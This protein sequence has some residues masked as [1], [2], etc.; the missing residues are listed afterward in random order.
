M[1]KRKKQAPRTARSTSKRSRRAPAE[2]S[3]R[4][5]RPAARATRRQ[6]PTPSAAPPEPAAADVV[7][8]GEPDLTQ[9]VVYIHGIGRHDDRDR[10]KEMWDVALFGRGMGRETIGA[11]WADIRH[12]NASA[13]T[14]STASSKV[15]KAAERDAFE[16]RLLSQLG[17]DDNVAGQAYGTKILPLP[18]FLRTPLTKAF[19]AAFVKDT[20]AY[21]YDDA[22]RRAMRQRLLDVIKPLRKEPFV[23]VAHS[24]GTMIAYDVLHGLEDACRVSRFVTLGSPLGIQEVQDR[25]MHLLNIKTSP[26]LPIPAGV[27]RWDNFAARFDPVAADPVLTD[28]FIGGKGIVRDYRI[29]NPYAWKIRDF[30]PHDSRGYLAD[31]EVRRVVYRAVG[32]DSTTRFVV[33]RDVM[34]A[35]SR[36]P[37]E[38][39]PEAQRLPVLIEVL[40]PQSAAVGETHA[41]MLNREA[42]L[43]KKRAAQADPTIDTLDGRIAVLEGQLTKLVGHGRPPAA[44]KRA[45]EA[46]RIQ[47]LRKYV[48]AHLTP[49]EVEELASRPGDHHVYAIWRNSSKRKLLTRSHGPLAAD[50]ARASY[51]ADG[52]GITWAVLDTGCQRGHP[53]FSSHDTV[54]DVLDCTTADATPQ[55][56][57]PQAADADGHGTHVCGI[58]AGQGRTNEAPPRDVL[59]IAPKARLVVYKVL[60]D[61]GRGE[62]AWII[63]AIDHIF[64]T[65]QSHPGLKIHGVNLSLGG[66]Y[67][68]SIY[69]CGFS[70][71]CKELRDLWRQGVVVCVAAGN[72]GIL[73]VTSGGEQRDLYAPLSIGDPANLDDCIA[74]GSVNADK[75]HLHG[76]S[77][78]SSRGPTADGRVKPD[79]VAPGE[80]ILSCNADFAVT[81][82]RPNGRKRL[83]REDSGTSMA[84]PHVSGLI[85]AF[86]SL[87][88]EFIGRPDEVKRIVLENC[89]DL[90]R[91]QYHQG[92]GMPNLMKMLMSS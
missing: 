13:K 1:A 65:N 70:P 47:P 4:F 74:V 30:N 56:L 22:F 6:P 46:A 82:R 76:I 81:K 52:R 90:G 38:D 62:D 7:T 75:P 23:L 9:P 5:A 63:K 61:Q 49:A 50:A 60:D 42:A 66:P 35:S 79:V 33:A 14:L 26:M 10:W 68:P 2:R 72:E 18:G 69:G 39:E 57:G 25:L 73:T 84:C 48:A 87:R 67:D 40:E 92:A 71:I 77:Y 37:Q 88:R 80:R 53:H 51:G 59:G 86:L 8:D 54:I 27:I 15:K 21:F 20:A 19:L 41:A 45:V 34:Q 24:Q 16:K 55:S 28:D 12:G 58:I 91:A 36:F 43:L 78:F 85:A 3:T 64:R 32:H 29:D 31:P 89:N 17:A 83:Y 11:Y 44:A